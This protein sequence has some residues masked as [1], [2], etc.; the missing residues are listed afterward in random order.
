[1]RWKF[2]VLT[3]A[4]FPSASAFAQTNNPVTNLPS[5][6]A[7]NPITDARSITRAKTVYRLIASTPRLHGRVQWYRSH[8]P[9]L[10]LFHDV[11][12]TSSLAPYLEVAFE[13]G[14]I[15]GNRDRLFHPYDLLRTVPSSVSSVP[16][17]S[18]DLFALSIPTLGIDRLPIAHPSDLTSE[19]GILG[20]LKSGV[21][22]LFSF[23][24]GGGSVFLY[25]HSSGYPWDLS[26]YTRIFR[27]VNRLNV[28]D[29]IVITYQGQR[30]VY[31]VTAKERVRADDLRPFQ[32]DRG[33]EE[34]ILYTC[35]PPDS[36]A[37]RLLVR[38]RPIVTLSGR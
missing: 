23:P 18:S 37:E 34:L 13:A 26:R 35:W 30:F 12:Q 28:S 14:L 10:P 7:G 6:Q 3:L 16:V 24:G 17:S 8:M 32:E 20:P 15:A 2:L 36:T 9:P 11:P 4:I 19:A 5:R 27:Q 33:G 29:P 21:G 22:H 31:Q 1:M 38:A 25:G